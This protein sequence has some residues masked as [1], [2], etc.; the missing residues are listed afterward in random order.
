MK[1]I[2]LKKIMNYVRKCQ[3]DGKN[4]AVRGFQLS[5]RSI[6]N[7]RCQHCY[8][9][10]S[11]TEGDARLSLDEVRRLADQFHALNAWE[12]GIQG[13]EPLAFPDLDDLIRAIRPSRFYVCLITNG[14]LM[15][16][17]IAERLAALGVDRVAVSIDGFTAQEHDTLRNKKGS[18]EKCLR[19]LELVKEAG[20]TAAINMVMG[21]YNVR[22]PESI[23]FFEMAAERGYEIV[24]NPATPTG[25]WNSKY[26]IMLTE[27]D[28]RYLMGL[29]KRYPNIMRDLWDFSRRDS[30]HVWGDPAGNLY[31]VSGNGD[32]F[33]HPYIFVSLGNI[34]TDAVEDAV[35]RAWKVRWFRDKCSHS[36][37]G[38]DR[39]FV[40]RFLSGDVSVFK[41]LDFEQAFGPEDLY[42]DG[43]EDIILN[44]L[45]T[46]A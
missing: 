2:A 7:F 14:Y 23:A 45:A 19:A 24:V 1:P 22:S 38:E 3:R 25:A 43:E 32:I 31:F 13:G 11:D 27:E 16:K 17:Q 46:A 26:E 28:S 37:A 6:C 21:N 8:V 29:R 35:K 5:Y 42:M 18:F 10:D 4:S 41:P 33:P 9:H 44:S 20:M 12:V 39:V 34:R 30:T 36:I 15:K 40:E